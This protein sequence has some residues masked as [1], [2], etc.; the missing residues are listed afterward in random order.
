MLEFFKGKKTY[1]IAILMLVFAITGFITQK[2]DQE[3]AIAII[4]QALGFS[5][6][7]AG[8]ASK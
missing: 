3:Q 1:A 7:R 8:V 6:L 5:A 2:L 4:L